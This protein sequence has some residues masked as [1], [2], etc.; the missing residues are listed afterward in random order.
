MLDMLRVVRRSP[1]FI[2]FAVKNVIDCSNQN[3]AQLEWNRQETISNSL[4]VIRRRGLQMQVALNYLVARRRQVITVCSLLLLILSSR[5]VTTRVRHVRSC[6]Q[7]TRNSGWTVTQRL[8]FLRWAFASTVQKKEVWRD[9][10][11][12]HNLCIIFGAWKI[13]RLTHQ[14]NFCR[15]FD[16]RCRIFDTSRT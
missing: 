12:K 13:R 8:T 5:S 1:I 14:L 6:P 11:N 16:W 9:H 3:D 15:I 4:R 10:I 2:Y 7:F